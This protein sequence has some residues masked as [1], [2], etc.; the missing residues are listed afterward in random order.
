MFSPLRWPTTSSLLPRRTVPAQR[1]TS[2]WTR[3]SRRAPPRLD[4][5]PLQRLLLRTLLLVRPV[6]KA[7]RRVARRTLYVLALI[8]FLLSLEDTLTKT[9]TLVLNLPLAQVI[10]A[11][12]Q[13][14]LKF[15]PFA[16]TVPPGDK[17]E[18]QWGAGPH[19]VSFSG[20]LCPV[21][22]S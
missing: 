11:P 12:S 22:L 14:V 10:V 17:I 5:E 7:E 16:I 8:D 18:Y 2:T 3:V 1:P 20:F 15:V 6:R 9:L 19:T 4:G 13:G 21:F